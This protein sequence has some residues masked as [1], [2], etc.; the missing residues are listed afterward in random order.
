MRDLHN[1]PD[2]TIKPTVKGGSIVTM[3]TVDYVKEAKRQF[4]N[5]EH[6]KTQD[7]DPTIPYNKYIHHLID[8]LRRVEIID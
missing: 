2:T 1:N 6:Y 8:Q 5:Q 3:N 4:F 7:K